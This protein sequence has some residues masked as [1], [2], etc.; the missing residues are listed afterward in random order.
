MLHGKSNE[1]LADGSLAR[2]EGKVNLI[3][4]SPPFPLNRKKR[5]GNETGEAYIKWLCAFGPLFKKMLA[6][7]GSIVVE[8]GNSWEPGMPVMST[9]AL[10][11]LLEFQEKND[12]HLCQEFIWHN[13][14]KLPSPAQWVNVER[15]RVK[16]SFTKLW[17]MASTKKPKASNQRVLQEYSKAMK[18]LLKRGTYNA[19]KRPSEHDISETAFL[20]DN[21][22]AIPSNVLTY[23]NTQNG[24]AYQTY[25]RENELPLHPARMPADLA[26]FFIKFLT[27]AGDV[28]LDPFGGSNTTGAAAEELE[29]FWISIEASEDYIK[30]SRGR[31]GD[32]ITFDSFTENG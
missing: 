29:R 3:F 20:R 27:V 25:C 22:G 10:R 28:V 1:I 32:R 2:F 30:G 16:D 15:S 11:A 23:A 7:D 12:L 26:K 19:G 14:A 8:M 31:F 18:T 21:G 13:P 17:W 9:L 6:P 24:D 4:T 5:Y